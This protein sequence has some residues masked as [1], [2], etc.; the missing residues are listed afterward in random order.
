[1][2]LHPQAKAYLRDLNFEPA[3]PV[4]EMTLA[5]ARASMEDNVAG[6][7]DPRQVAEVRDLAAPRP[8][9]EIPLR[10]YRPQADGTLPVVVFFH[11][12]GWVLGSLNTHDGLC[13]ALANAAGCAVISVD[14]RL[15]PEH[16]FPAATDDA[17]TATAW[18]AHEAGQLRLDGTRLAVAGDSAGG[19]LAAATALRARD[20]DGP[21]LRLQLLLY[22]ATDCYFETPSYEEFAEH[23]MLTRDAMFWFWQQYLPSEEHADE[24]YAAPA[25][26]DDLANL[27]PAMV[28]TAECDPLRDEGEAYA[29]QLHAAG[30]TVMA[31][32]YDGMIHGFVRRLGAFD[33]AQ[34]ALNQMAAALRGAFDE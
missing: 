4:Y 22:P 7:G 23:Y 9:G 3:P 28:I 1:M 32:R 5:E 12:G 6:L 13:R 25:R 21:P 26:A 14:Y 27:P 24:P 18:I 8:G 15:A 17:Y 29:D 2:P 19:N 34:I 16:K 10:L 33:Q 20:Q 11:G 30:V 31:T